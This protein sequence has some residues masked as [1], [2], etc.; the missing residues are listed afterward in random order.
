MSSIVNEIIRTVF[1]LFFF[2]FLRKKNQPPSIT[3]QVPAIISKRISN[4]FCDKECFDK[5][6]PDC[7]N[8][9]TKN[10]FNDFNV[11]SGFSGF[12]IKFTPAPP[13]RRKHSRTIC[14]YL[15]FSS[16]LKTNI[17]KIFLRLVEKN[18]PQHNK[19]YNMFNRNMSSNIQNPNIY[20]LKNLNAPAVKES[21]CCKKLTAN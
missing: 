7:N 13:Q 20:L 1:H 9:L 12:N 16:D 11:F 21:S 4:I 19:H 10:G 5:A 8:A 18:S 17:D 6:A 14:F 2:F 15:P 3:K